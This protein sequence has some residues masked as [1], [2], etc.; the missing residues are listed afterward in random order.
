MMETPWSR[1]GGTRNGDVLSLRVRWKTKTNFCSRYSTTSPIFD[2]HLTAFFVG[3]DSPI[4]V[5]LT[6]SSRLSRKVSKNH[7]LSDDNIGLHYRA[8][9]VEHEGN[10]VWFWIGGHADYDRLLGQA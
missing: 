7:F 8:V 5:L 4:H 1:D 9:A 3:I 10:M 2:A 6:P